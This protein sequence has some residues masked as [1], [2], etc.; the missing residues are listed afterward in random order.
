MK[1][2]NKKISVIMASMCLVVL[3]LSGCG[4]DTGTSDKGSASESGSTD[5]ATTSN[6]LAG[7]T[8]FVVG[9]ECNYEPYNWTVPNETD[10]SI[11][12]DGSI[13]AGYCDGYDVMISNKIAKALGL[14]LLV[15]KFAWDGLPP[16]LAAGEIDA[17]IA[18]MTYSDEREAGG[19]DFTSEYY[20]GDMVMLVKKGRP[21]ASFTSLDQYKGLAVLGQKNTTYDEVIDQIPEVDH[22]TPKGSYS[23]VVFALQNGEAVAA[24]AE[25]PVALGVVHTNP[26][27]VIQEFAE[28]KGFK[29]VVTSPSI[30]MKEGSRDQEL[31]KQVQAALDGISESDRQAMMD[32]AV[33]AEK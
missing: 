4:T 16:A 30:A 29:D 6:A 5:S 14:E 20:Q 33:A 15:R 24:P 11:P 31:F 27:L 32:A 17:I 25:R 8:Q 18:G 23:E 7:K 3:T 1:K 9:M 19:I 22:K 12:I 28:G 13:A 26:D 10:T 2:F 21:E